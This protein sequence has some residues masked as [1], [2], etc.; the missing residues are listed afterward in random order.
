[1]QPDHCPALAVSED[2]WRDAGDDEDPTSRLRIVAWISGTM[3][4][5]E[6]IAVSNEDGLQSGAR[7]W[8]ETYLGAL[9]LA[10]GGDGP[11]NTIQIRG[12]EYV[13]VLAPGT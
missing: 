1:M 3:H 4:H 11:Y 9:D 5:L 8:S 7:P 6:A 2:L 10:V 13:L 12:R